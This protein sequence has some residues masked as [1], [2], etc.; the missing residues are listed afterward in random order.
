MLRARVLNTGYAGCKPRG[1]TTKTRAAVLVA[2][3][4]K[5]GTGSNSLEIAPIIN[6]SL[7]PW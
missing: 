2:E 1:A 4:A 7:A 3:R 5:L 6:V